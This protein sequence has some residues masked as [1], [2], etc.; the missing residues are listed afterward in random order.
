MVFVAA[1]FNL[2]LVLAGLR[3]V[4]GRLQA[5]PVVGIGP[6]AFSNRM[7]ISA[8]MP[9][10]P[11]RTRDSVWRATPNA[12]AP[13]VTFRLNGSRQASLMEWPG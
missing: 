13:S 6:T 8:D 3:E 10:R 11:F 9:A 5:Q 1:H 2:I 4:I 12:L 7:A